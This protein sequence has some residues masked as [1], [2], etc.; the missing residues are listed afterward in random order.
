MKL[1][2]SADA[3]ELA[4]ES[5]SGDWSETEMASDDAVALAVPDPT[6]RSR[7]ARIVGLAEAY[8]LPAVIVI[9]IAFFS[10]WPKTSESFL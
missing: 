4:H 2:R 6:G 3:P 7:Q 8:T 1:T 5:E 9:L 10:T